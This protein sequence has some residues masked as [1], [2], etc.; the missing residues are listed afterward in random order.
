MKKTLLIFVIE[1]LFISCKKEGLNYNQKHND[2]STTKKIFLIAL[3]SIFLF[4]C[5]KNENLDNNKTSDSAQSSDKE[6]YSELIGKLPEIEYK[7]HIPSESTAENMLNQLTYQRA[8]QMYLWAIPAV[9][10]Q[11][12]RLANKKALGGEDQYKVAYLGGLLKS[13]ITHL[14]GNPDAMYIDYFFDTHDGP[15]V[16][17]VPPTLPG[18]LDD[19]WQR[20]VIDVIAPISPTGKYLIVPPD[21][22]GIAPKGFVVAKPQTYVSW[23]LLRGNVSKDGS[24]DAA[25]QEMKSKLKIYPLSELGKKPSRPLEFIDIT[26]MEINRVAPEGLAFFTT[27]ASLV[28][29]EYPEMQDVYNTGVLHSLGMKAGT[30]FKPDPKT[31]KLLTAAANT[32]Q[33][34]ARTLSFRNEK[35]KRIWK[36]RTFVMPF[37]GN[38]PDFVVDHGVLLDARSYFFY[39]ACGTSELMTTQKPGVGQAYPSGEMTG[40]GKY[41]DGGKT[42]KLHLPGPIPAKLYWSITLYDTKDRSIIKNNAGVARIS[43]FTGPVINTDGSYDLYFG[44][45]PIKGKE[46]N[47]VKTVANQGWIF[48]FRLYG[49]EEPYFNGKWKPDDL[50]EIQK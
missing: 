46:K 4:S 20:P 30:A 28:Q 14:T 26:T 1:F 32:G 42:Y 37:I 23:L 38:R 41:L 11:Q 22:K 17:E 8:T 18:L 10:M 35:D 45:D 49:P 47:F 21:W 39:A 27:L 24:T 29:D 13:N 15:I 25:V 9:G 36:D 19:M 16:L 31:E 2:M 12:Y 5:K 50:V 40:D 43:S 7:Y 3:I 33:A 34:M 44:P 6:D 48:L